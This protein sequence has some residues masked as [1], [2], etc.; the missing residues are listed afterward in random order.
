MN[1]RSSDLIFD[2]GA[3]RGE[4]SDFYLKLGY[5][6]VAVEANP[7]LAEELRTRF[8]KEM[9]ESR[10]VVVDKAIGESAGKVTF[11]VNK[12]LSVWGT[13]DPN[14][15]KRNQGLGA[16]SEEI[17]VESTRFSDIVA[18]HG[19]PHY[20]KIDIEGADMLCVKALKDVACRPKFVSV[21]SNKTSWFDLLD[22]F[23]T[24][25]ALG[26][27]KFKIVD[28][29]NHVDGNYHHHDGQWVGYKFPK[30]STGPFG[31]DLGGVWLTKSQAIRAYIP[32]FFLYK[33]IGDNTFLSKVLK[34]VPVLRRVLDRVSWYDTHA[35][36]A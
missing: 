33:T 11:Y 16:D 7:T 30:G 13:A 27:T 34:H 5:R 14:W 26:Y 12:K 4:D 1:D 3:H 29:R 20:I 19:C 24:F 10:F 32:I 9:K 22:E 21:E 31:D 36:R 17:T 28:Q 35:T 23:K 2:V 15:A 18:Q 25:D 6:V 8:A